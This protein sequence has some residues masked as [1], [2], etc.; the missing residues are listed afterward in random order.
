[1]AKLVLSGNEAVALAVKLSRVHVV[2]AYPITPQT[3]I[4][5]EIAEYVER[6]ELEA[7]SIAVESE[8]SAMAACIGAAA[9]GARAFTATSSQGLLYMGEMVFWAAGARLPVVMAVVNRAV[10]PPWSI[11]CDHNDAMAFRDAGWVQMWAESVQEALDMTIQAF[12]VAEDV[13]VLLPAMVCLDSFILSHA[14][15]PVE[16]PEQSAVDEFLPEKTPAPYWVDPDNPKSYCTIATPD[17][18]MEFRYKVE[19]AMRGAARV[20]EEV[21]EEWGRLTGRNCRGLVESYRCDDAEVCIVLAGSWA[22]EAKEAADRMREGG[23]RV[24]VARLRFTRPFPAEQL[25]RAV[26]AADAIAVVDRS[27]SPGL[28]SVLLSEVVASLY[29]RGK[30]PYVKGFIAGLGGRDVR[31]SDFKLIVE[32]AL[33]GLRGGEELAVEWVGLRGGERGHS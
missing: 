4:V 20:V 16:A 25:R 29:S 19:E 11:W 6:G 5:E 10:A 1:M 8:H 26:E 32:S 13:R 12:K 2:A 14:Y 18:Y 24:G 15:E 31:V 30:S 23:V 27:L 3:Q 9:G 21:S 28:P 33:K 17:T 22:G 7:R